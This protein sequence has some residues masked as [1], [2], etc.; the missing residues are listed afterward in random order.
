M[1]D[2]GT[3]RHDHILL[4]RDSFRVLRLAALRLPGAEGSGARGLVA[5]V[6]LLRP[7]AAP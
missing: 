3:A 5:T 2:T 6:Q 4:R 7:A 1:A